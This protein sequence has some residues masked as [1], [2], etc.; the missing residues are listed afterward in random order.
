M[1][2]SRAAVRGQLSRLDLV[3]GV[4]SGKTIIRE[5]Y[6]EVPFKITRLYYP[7]DSNLAQLIIMNTTAGLFPG[8]RLAMQIRVEPGAR[9]LITSQASTKVHPGKGV[10]EQS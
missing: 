9:V 1:D 10:A 4:K 5:S 3:F 2:S 7:E 6:S 8:D